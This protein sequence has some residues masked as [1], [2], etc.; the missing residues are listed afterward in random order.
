ML[1]KKILES[2]EVDYEIVQLADKKIEFC[3]I[4]EKCINMDC[5]LEDDLNDIFHKMQ[6][7]DGLVFTLPKYLFVGSKF[8]CFLE[9]LDS[10]SHMRR[11]EGYQVTF[12]NRDYRLFTTEK[13]FCIFFTSGTGKMEG[14]TMKIAAEYIGDLGLKLIRH[15]S[16]PFLGVMVKAGDGVGDVMKD[17]KGIG[18]CKR[19]AKKLIDSIKQ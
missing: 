12:K 19:L 6:K 11:H 2:S 4:C 18:E 10:I 15:D 14:E 3:N 17:E 16:P 8:L 1:T 9:R 5:V 13:P 7:T